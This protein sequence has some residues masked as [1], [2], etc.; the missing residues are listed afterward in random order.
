MARKRLSPKHCHVRFVELRGRGLASLRL[1][2]RNND[3]S[4]GK[5]SVAVRGVRMVTVNDA[6]FISGE[7]SRVDFQIIPKSATCWKDGSDI[8]CKVK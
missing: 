8:E 6:A 1:D 3:G 4:S 5:H 2:C 7:G